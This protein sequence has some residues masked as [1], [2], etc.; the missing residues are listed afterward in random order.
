MSEQAQISFEQTGIANVLKHHQLVVPANQRDYAW[1]EKEVTT[2]FQDLAEAV[3]NDEA[4]FLGSIV[5]ITNK[6]VIEV[7]DGQ[8]RLATTTILLKA[9]Q[10]YL[11]TS[12]KEIADSINS[13]FLSGF[14]REKREHIPKIKLNVDDNDYFKGILTDQTATPVRASHKLL[15]AA[16]NEAKAQIQRVV[17]P[18]NEKKHADV[19]NK[20]VN[21]LEKK[22]L[23]ILLRVSSEAN[24]Y[25]MFETL[26][27]RGLKTSQ[28]DLIKNYL[29]GRAD[30]RIDEVKQKWASMRSTLEALGDE[31]EHTVSF[32][33]HALIVLKGPVK[34]TAVY[35]AVQTL[36]KSGQ[37]TV[38]LLSN[39]ESLA[40]TYTAIHSRDHEKWGSYSDR[41]R[42]SLDVLNLFDLKPVRPLMLAVA[43]SFSEQE[44][45]KAFKYL[46]SCTIRLLIASSSPTSGS[47]ETSISTAAHKIREEEIKCT[48]D[49][50][51]ALYNVIPGDEQFRQKFEIA[52]FSTVKL[53][54]Y[55]LRSLEMAAKGESEPWMIPNN[56]PQSITLEHVLPKK[57]QDN[58]PQ[59]T[60]DEVRSNVRRLGNM[61]LLRASLNS[62]LKSSAFADKKQQFSQSPYLTTKQVA[63]ATDWT[64]STI[65]HRQKDLAVLALKAWPL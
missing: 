57:P 7:V 37:A 3:E 1:T 5:T 12:E 39:L 14:N 38:T 47:I 11:K 18:H 60:E 64:P 48:D 24:A 58:W 30:D 6:D 17:S 28:S 50:K 44:A 25:K 51:K 40:N 31:P 62:S 41:T 35:E 8:Q 9:I 43:H 13:E 20:W 21:F 52:T 33:R 65:G 15:E 63:D 36:A 22:A 61:V 10:S 54:R 53:A 16:Y 2:L 32:L 56:D 59:F 42:D 34:E 46:I 49:L 26:N 27:D 4:Y 29:F 23:V 19:L 55:Y 45:E